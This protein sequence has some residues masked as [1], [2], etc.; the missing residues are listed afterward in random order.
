M[1]KNRK[2]K[3]IRKRRKKIKFEDL[4]K[5]FLLEHKIFF[6]L[7]PFIFTYL[8]LNYESFLLSITHEG[9]PLDDAYIVFQFAKQFSEGKPFQYND[10]ILTTGTSTLLWLII[11]A[12]AYKIFGVFFNDYVIAFLL[13]SKFISSIFLFLTIFEIYYISSKYLKSKIFGVLIG[14]FLSAEP[15]LIW[16]SLSGME[17]CLF[18]F[19]IV[20]MILFFER[21]NIY[22]SALFGGLAGLTRIEGMLLFPFLILIYFVKKKFILNEFNFEELKKMLI[23]F[24]IYFLTTIPWP[25]ANL[26][27]SGKP[28]PHTFYAK[29]GTTN[30]IKNFGNLF[31]FFHTAISIV[32]DL[33][34]NLTIFLY[35][36]I[37]LIF[38]FKREI[39]YYLIIFLL[40]II[41]YGI[42]LPNLNGYGRYLM[43]IE[44][45]LIFIS[46]SGM[47]LVGSLFIPKKYKI[48]INYSGK[49]VKVEVRKIVPFLIALF[50]FPALFHQVEMWKLLYTHN[51]WSTNTIEVA[52]GYWVRENVPEN[53]S[54]ASHDAGALKFI[55]QRLFYDTFGLVEPA[56]KRGE[57]LF[58]FLSKNKIDYYIGFLGDGISNITECVPVAKTKRIDQLTITPGYEFY[59]WKCNWTSS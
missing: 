31:A 13:I 6:L 14:I 43:P 40:F 29:G 11:L 28:L 30:P 15:H 18:S 1:G 55:G 56:R 22:L 2:Y 37:I 47:Y 53:A 10:G 36:A 52:S 12:G 7:V 32:F 51:V 21:G 42:A 50:S 46:F 58:D 44:P 3:K 25:I 33:G 16:A 27:I 19:L 41:L 23:P 57:T 8:R 38:I 20:S 17:I 49:R 34:Y 24:L 45:L 9:S 35:V 4:V 39:N 26:L 5:K 54:I 59:M 48:K